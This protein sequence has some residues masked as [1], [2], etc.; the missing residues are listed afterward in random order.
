VTRTRPVDDVAR[1]A[2]ARVADGRDGEGD[3]ATRRQVVKILKF[4]H[5]LSYSRIVSVLATLDPPIRSNKQQISRDVRWIQR[6][7]AAQLAP[8]HFNARA[9]IAELRE[10]YRFARHE[11]IARVLRDDLRGAEVCGLLRIVCD[12]TEHEQQLLQDC[13]LLDRKLGEI[14]ID[15]AKAATE[16]L[17]TGD[18]LRAIFDQVR[19]QLD[20]VDNAEYLTAGERKLLY[21][22]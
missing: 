22:D 14:V 9:A 12:S 13:G 3:A 17:P 10:N 21:G 15:P 16:R 18:E 8:D 2:A 6:H 11:A 1:V 19:R 4:V 20:T 5:G 7:W